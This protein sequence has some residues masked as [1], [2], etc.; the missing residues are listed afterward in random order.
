MY[1]IQIHAKLSRISQLV[2]KMIIFE[3]SSFL[4]YASLW[5]EKL[6]KASGNQYNGYEHVLALNSE[7]KEGQLDPGTGLQRQKL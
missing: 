3:C 1:G 6:H 5:V 7:D 4:R 2:R